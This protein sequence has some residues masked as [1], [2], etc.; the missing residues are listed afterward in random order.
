MRAWPAEGVTRIP[1]WVYSD[2]E[3]YATSSSASSADRSG[4]T[5]RSSAR[6]RRRATSC[7]TWIGE[8]AGRRRAAAAMARCTCSLNR[9]AH[10][11]VQF[12]R[13]PSGHADELMCPYHQWTYDLA[14]NLLGVPFRKGVRRQ[15]R[16][17]RRLRARPSTASTSL[18]V[19]NAHGV[20]FASLRRDAAGLRGVP[21][22]DDARL[23][24]PRLRRPRRSSV[25]GYMRQRIPANWKL[26][27]ENIKDPY[28]ASP[29]ARVPRDVR[30]VPRRQPVGAPRWTRP[31]ATA[32]WSRARR[33]AGERGDGGDAL[34]P[35]RLQL[36]RS[37]P[38][39]PGAR[40]PGRRDGRHADARGRTSSCSSSRTRWRCASSCR[41]ARAS[42]T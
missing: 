39:R 12:C 31:G 19:A 30:P 7:R 28:H 25:L 27:F 8:H 1:Y 16:H 33:A 11:G 10:R 18:P 26:M 35:R 24:R 2:P 34:V 4:A 5:S 23:V 22:R 15:G 38:A 32:C 20:V 29:A 13:E 9:C 14:G 6:S 21:R 41:G 17:A 40:V 36:Q 42:S 3:L 37:A